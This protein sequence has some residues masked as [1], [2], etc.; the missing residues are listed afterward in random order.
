M[1]ST[2]VRGLK[3]GNVGS[4]DLRS[5]CAL[6]R[7]LNGSVSALDHDGDPITFAVVDGPENGTL[8][9][10]PATGGYTYTPDEHFVGTDTFT[11]TA[12]D[13]VADSVPGTV[14]IEV[15]NQPPTAGNSSGS[16][17]HDTP[18]YGSV[19]GSDSNGDPAQLHRRG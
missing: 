19:G 1:H 18:L 12:N 6:D 9:L 14:T 3:L 17:L 11:F 16:T 5:G 8:E 10:D 15:T 2:L 4:G 13:G 7:T